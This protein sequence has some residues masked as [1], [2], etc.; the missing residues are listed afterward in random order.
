MGSDNLNEYL[1]AVKWFPIHDSEMY[2]FVGIVD[3]WVKN[4]DILLFWQVKPVVQVFQVISRVTYIFKL[5]EKR[6][7]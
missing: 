2:E 6:V 4:N 1:L 3:E 5:Q 7:I